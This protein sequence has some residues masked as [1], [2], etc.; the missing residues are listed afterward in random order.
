[1][2]SSWGRSHLN[3]LTSMG[4]CS[5]FIPFLL[6]QLGQGTLIVVSVESPPIL[7]I[8]S[9]AAKMPWRCRETGYG[10]Q[11]TNVKGKPFQ[12]APIISQFGTCTVAISVG[13]AV[14]SLL[15]SLFIPRP[16]LG[17]SLLQSLIACSPLI[18]IARKVFEIFVGHYPVCLPDVTSCDE[19]LCSVK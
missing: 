18:D 19:I 16:F 12:R 15:I 1:M 8:T 9:S 14:W 10:W 4:L 7:G 3:V 5:D 11:Y 17:L 2:V 6:D 13:Q